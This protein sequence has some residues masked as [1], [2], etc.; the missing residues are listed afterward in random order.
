MPTTKLAS[1]P[2]PP[3][4]ASR[5]VF[6][7]PEPVVWPTGT[8]TI[9]VTPA[10]AAPAA[11]V[12]AGSLP[13][14][15]SAP[16]TPKTGKTVAPNAVPKTGVEAGRKIRVAFA[17]RGATAKAGILGV[18][19]S[20]TDVGVVPA[21]GGP[22]KADVVPAGTPVTVSVSYQGFEGAFG[23]DYANRLR[24]F[25]VPACA[26]T[27]PS[28]SACR[29]VPL[30]TTANAGK[31]TLTA[32][33][34]AGSAPT[35]V[36]AGAGVA[37]DSGDFSATALAPSSTW[38]GGG[39]SGDFTWSYPLR[40]PPSTGGDTPSLA[41]G[42]SS[43]SVDGRVAATNNQPSWVGDGFDLGTGFIERKYQ[44]C[45]DDMTGGNNTV[46]TGDL[47]WQRDNATISLN[48][49]SLELVHDN[50]HPDVWKL[51]VDDGSRVQH[52][53]GASNGDLGE[54]AASGKPG[55]VGE[56]WM[57]TTPDG[58]QYWF[59][60]NQLPGWATGKT[61]TNSV[62]TVPVF[63]NHVNEPCHKTTFAA[64]WCWQG[65]R[66]NLD[67][68]VDPNQNAQ[69]YYYT[70][71][72][73]YYG[74][75]M[76]PA[77]R[78]AYI[79][80]HYLTR[81]DYGFRN[82]S[83]Y[84]TTAGPTAQIG[85]NVA[86]RCL[87]NTVTTCAP[88]QLTAI[89]AGYWPDVPF[90]R[91]C[92]QNTD[93]TNKLSPAFFTRKMLTKITTRVWD[94]PTA[95]FRD[96]DAWTLGHTFPLPGD[97]SPKALWL[98]SITHTSLVGGTAAI[99]AVTFDPIQMANRV[100]G[101]GDGY[102]ALN[103]MRISAIHNETGGVTS[104]TYS[105]KMCT[106]SGTVHMPASPDSNTYLCFPSYWQ[107][108]NSA[109]PTLDWF[110]K[111]VVVQVTDADGAA[112]APTMVT[113]YGYSGGIAWHWDDDELSPWKWRTWSEYRGYET[114]TTRQ[115]ETGQTQSASMT[116]YY[117]GMDQ[118]RKSDGSTPPVNIT[119]TDGGTTR[120]AWPLEGRVRETV[121]Y[122]GPGGAIQSGTVTD[123]TITGPTATE[124]KDGRGGINA[125]MVTTTG[126][127]D[128]IALSAGGWR[129]TQSTTTY[130]THAQPTQVDNQGDTAT[131]ADDQCT[132]TTYAENTTAW[133]LS[134][135]SR[136]ETVAKNCATTPT[137]PDD[138][139]DDTLTSY[140]TQAN[141]VAPTA[142][143]PTTVEEINGW[144]TDTGKPT[145]LTTATGTYDPYGRPLVAV[146]AKNNKTTTAYTPTTGGPVT[147]TTITNPLG[148]ATTTTIEPAW[149]T[150][151]A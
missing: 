11:P 45:A 90:D 74:L 6:T 24:L 126:N 25:S 21:P 28:A 138:V 76:T 30:P 111:Y 97:G 15:V 103:R 72:F 89:N 47:C 53:L 101:L 117:R 132:T 131:T 1:K 139:I 119:D 52:F 17:D 29:L 108:P 37:G 3:N 67:Y 73:N 65:Y 75:N 88:A 106:R 86:E 102:T 39:S 57:L 91:I 59:G 94:T 87:P 5:K 26:M 22:S 58:T 136:S 104:V 123:S 69:A 116:R 85:F 130:N 64:S 142:G 83:A 95:K 127:R 112:M 143:N 41:L 35:F 149:G 145:Y 121:T 56:W 55:D 51:R 7:K 133:M 4:A 42:Y 78:T 84:S 18:L 2:I 62:D 129:R 147:A 12:R 109:N 20:V 13:V 140:D 33:V 54:A 63:G 115:G 43:G 114:V 77:S 128:R 124:N 107:G 31:K 10:A 150:P 98:S 122:D 23:G 9:D 71:E 16:I 79:A 93:C 14:W 66:W 36:A 60:R 40:A 19:L 70:K 100:D 38:S 82:G 135:P 134:Y 120:D 118:D 110:H 125:Y 148:F 144:D 151:I 8:A 96:V 99:P 141:G 81:I 50:A 32:A 49:K 137:R 80:A 61:E 27:T 113:N 34:P 48:G 146:D 105:G 68:V 92:P 44:G 46:K